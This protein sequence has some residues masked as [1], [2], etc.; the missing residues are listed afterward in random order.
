MCVTLVWLFVRRSIQAVDVEAVAVTVKELVSYALTLNANNQS[1]LITQADIYFGEDEEKCSLKTK[2]CC[3]SVGCRWSTEAQTFQYFHCNIFLYC[4]ARSQTFGYFDLLKSICIR[5]N[6]NILALLTVTNEYS[7]ALN[8]YLQAG[9][10]CSDFFTKAVPPDVYTDQAGCLSPATNH[11][12]RS[13]VRN[14]VWINWDH[15]P[16]HHVCIWI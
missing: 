5:S 16:L 10:V 3:F 4:C 6:P 1:W 2:F 9:A 7:A 8:L 13:V 12:K 15:D 11:W 14:N